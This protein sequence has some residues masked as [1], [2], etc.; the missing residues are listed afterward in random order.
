MERLT[1]A[2]PVLGVDGA[3]GGWVV[4]EFNATTQACAV[5][6]V[7]TISLVADRLRL[8]DVS[9]AVVDMPIGLSAGG[10][11]PVDSLARTRLGSRRATFFPTPIRDVLDHVHFGLA[12]MP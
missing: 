1:P 11:R 2:I 6:L 5:H 4:A 12:R 9:V 7:D 10:D 3:R 8:R